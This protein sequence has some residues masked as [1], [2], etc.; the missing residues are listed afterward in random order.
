[1]GF[2]LCIRR[3]ASTLASV[4]GR[5]ARSQAVSVTVNRSSL[6][7]KT[8]LLRPFVSRGFP[9]STATEPLKS[10][11]KLLQVIDSEI[12]DSFDADDHDAVIPCLHHLIPGKKKR[13]CGISDREL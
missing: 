13:I 12:N 1:M 10:D 5:V 2:A 9:Y 3:S 8:S 11:Q 6:V 4:C 7:P